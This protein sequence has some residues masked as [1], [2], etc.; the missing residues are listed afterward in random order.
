M[1]KEKEITV[2][3]V[4][5]FELLHD[6]FGLAGFDFCF[7]FK[8]GKLKE[9]FIYRRQQESNEGFHLKT[10]G[11]QRNFSIY[12]YCDKQ[13]PN[14]WKCGYCK[15]HKTICFRVTVP[16]DTNTIRFEDFSIFNI[17]FC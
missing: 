1:K 5:K 17:I 9:I 15:E 16:N 14:I 7:I 10:A 6:R 11:H 8:Y 4:I 2:N 12:S 13:D 3:D